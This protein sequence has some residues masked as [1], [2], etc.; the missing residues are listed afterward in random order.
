MKAW[1]LPICERPDWMCCMC[2]STAFWNLG[3]FSGRS[4]DLT[5]ASESCSACSSKAFLQQDGI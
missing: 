4:P 5:S 3:A 2:T 1:R